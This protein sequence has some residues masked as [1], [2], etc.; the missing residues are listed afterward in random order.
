MAEDE[1][2]VT[3]TTLRHNYPESVDTTDVYVEQASIGQDQ[4]DVRFCH[5]MHQTCLTFLDAQA[6]DELSTFF[7]EAAT[8]LRYCTKG[9]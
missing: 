2:L 9:A 1:R 8:K 5:M 6:L 7:A 3:T 4:C